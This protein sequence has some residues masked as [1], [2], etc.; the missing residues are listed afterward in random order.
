[1]NSAQ[2][3]GSSGPGG[4]QEVLRRRWAIVLNLA[5]LGVFAAAVYVTAV[6]QVYTATATASVAGAVQSGG[7]NMNILLPVRIP[8]PN[9]DART[10]RSARV[11]RIAGHMLRSSLPPLALSEKVAVTLPPNSGVL[12][13]TCSAPTPTGAVACANAFAAAYVKNRRDSANAASIQQIARLKS[14]VSSL[15]KAVARLRT[16][17]SALPSNSADRVARTELASSQAQLASLNAQ[18]EVLY[19]QLPRSSGGAIITKAQPPGQPGG[20]NKSL[21]LQSG[22]AAGLLLGLIAA[23]VVDRRDPWIYGDGETER[24]R[25]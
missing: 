13:I 7:G 16:K 14:Q 24:Y 21:V 9:G 4:C 5:G 15:Q 25:E 18:M 17:I 8:D 2:R 12:D 20:P 6:P 19:G 10:V 23:F 1:M 22:L 11:A 3:P